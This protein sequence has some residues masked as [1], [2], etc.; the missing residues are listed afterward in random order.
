MQT[1]VVHSKPYLNNLDFNFG[2]DDPGYSLLVGDP[3][4]SAQEERMAPSRVVNR[5][6]DS[7]IPPTSAKVPGDEDEGGGGEES[8]SDKLKVITNARP[9]TPSDGLMSPSELAMLFANPV[10]SAYEEG[11]TKLRKSSA[12]VP[13]YGD[14]V[15]IQPARRGANEPEW[16]SYTHFWQAVLGAGTVKTP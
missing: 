8:K 15:A 14:N 2:P 6:L 16:T 12:N 1:V 9:A 10:R 3:L 4:L 5:S 7:S 13:T 11:L